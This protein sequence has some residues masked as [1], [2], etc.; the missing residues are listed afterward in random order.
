MMSEKDTPYVV[1]PYLAKVLLLTE[2]GTLTFS[3][4]VV[5]VDLVSVTVAFSC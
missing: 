4:V 5:V 3:T 2:I 1:R